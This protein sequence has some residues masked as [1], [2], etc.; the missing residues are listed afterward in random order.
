VIG[1]GKNLGMTTTAE[2]VETADQLSVLS[3]EGCD[4]IQGFPF[5]PAA[6]RRSGFPAGKIPGAESRCG[7]CSVLGPNA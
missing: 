7:T 4:E 5:S 3:E 1:L 6:R 2:D